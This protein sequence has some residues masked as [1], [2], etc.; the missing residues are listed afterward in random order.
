M[1]TDGRSWSPA[2][3]RATP[4]LD[5]QGGPRRGLLGVGLGVRS[6]DGF[7]SGDPPKRRKI[8]RITTT[9]VDRNSDCQF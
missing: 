6:R 7:D 8:E 2:L 3:W 4:K 1:N 5:S 9:A